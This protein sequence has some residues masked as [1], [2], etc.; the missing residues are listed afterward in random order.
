MRV[1][2]TKSLRLLCA[3]AHV[4]DAV[5][6]VTMLFPWSGAP[7]RRRHIIAWSKTTLRIFGLRTAYNAPLPDG[8]GARL[9]VANHI[10]WL[11]I[12]AIWFSTDTTFVA[13]SEV[14]QWPVIGALARRL[15]VIFI[16]RSRRRY[17]LT[18][19]RQITELLIQG[20]SVCIFPEGTSTNGRDLDLFHPALFQPAVD[21]GVVVQPIAIRYF[22]VEG[23]FASEVAFTGDMSLVQS[24]CRLAGA[25]PID[26]DITYLPPID[27]TG[28]DRKRVSELAH[29][30]IDRRLREPTG[31]WL[32]E[33]DESRA[34][35]PYLIEA[36][37]SD[38][39]V[40]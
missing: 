9:L 2:L 4:L 37:P 6:R 21:A 8:A 18:A 11:D 24:M 26:I 13:K 27:P 31:G 10:S 14:G 15:G 34:T 40:S 16:D 39:V 29:A 32:F 17:A 28:L 3:A 36:T 19:G 35:R 1:T 20:R 5:V 23:E 12:V 38:L 22:N 33:P 25:A 7:L 30:L